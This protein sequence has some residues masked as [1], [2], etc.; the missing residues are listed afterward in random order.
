MELKE[1]NGQLTGVVDALEAA[2][3]KFQTSKGPSKVKAS[4]LV[5]K[6]SAKKAELEALIAQETAAQEKADDTEA[7][8]QEDTVDDTEAP[9]KTRSAASTDVDELD[10]GDRVVAKNVGKFTLQNK[11]VRFPPNMEIETV[12]TPFIRSQVEAANFVLLAK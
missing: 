9:V 1:L 7:P 8:A 5:E 4:N 3:E 11:G 10:A 2:V 6:L 12:M